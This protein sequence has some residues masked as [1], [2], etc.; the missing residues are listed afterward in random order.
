MKFTDLRLLALALMAFVAFSCEKAETET[1]DADVT[2]EMDTEAMVADEAA[3]LSAGM[4]N[5][6]PDQSNVKWTGSKVGGEHYGNIDINS[7]MFNVS[8]G[9]I[10]DGKFNINMA[11]IEVVDLAESPEDAAK[12]KGHLESDDFF[13]VKNYPNAMFNITN[14][15]PSSG[16]EGTHTVTG[17][18]TIKD[19]TNQV[20]FPA[21][22]QQEGDILKIMAD[23]TFDR[24][25]W[26]V[27]YGSS[28]FFDLAA[29]KVISDEIVLNMNLQANK[30]AM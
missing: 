30:G 15:Q 27:K 20:S 18:L 6:N 13:S 10:V 2:T 16:A 23:V 25:K 21:T 5:I 8:N 26:D 4:Y 29:D 11:S 17:D 3:M 12:L 24:S 28:S 22:I 9:T 7:G 19:K 14:V 1:G